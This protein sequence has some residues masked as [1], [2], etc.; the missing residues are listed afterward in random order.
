MTVVS[1]I[2]AKSFLHRTRVAIGSA[3]LLLSGVLLTSVQATDAPL[4]GPA[5]TKTGAPDSELRPFQI[6]PRAAGPDSRIDVSFLLE[7]PAG[8]NGFITARDGHLVKPDGSRQRFWGV[9][10]TDWSRGSV[11]IPDKAD[12]EFHA[13]TLA[14]AGV[15]IV[16]LTFLDFVAP[17]GIIDATRNDT[18]ALDA[19]Q[20]DK[21][22]WWIAALK[23]QGIYTDL[24]L[25]VG[26]TYKEGDGIADHEQIGWAKAL[27]IFD[28]KLIE[29]TKEFA[30][31]LLT[32]RNAYTNTEYRNE[33]AIAIVEV[34][35][36][37]SLL[38][39]WYNDRLRPLDAPVSDAN[40]RPIPARYSEALDQLYQN[41]LQQT[42]GEAGLTNLRARI[43][44]SPG[45]PV[46]RLR[47]ND[48]GAAPSEQFQAE[49]SFYTTLERH[50]YRDMQGYLKNTLKVRAL[51]LGSNDFLG[52]QSFYPTVWA[53]LQMD[54]VDA[55]VY[56]QHPSWPGVNNTPQ[57]NNP[58]WSTLVRLGRAAV[59]GKPF[60]VSEVN[61]AFPNDWLCE[62][63]PTLAA[64]AALQDWDAVMWYTYEPKRSAEHPGYIGDAFDISHDPVRWTQFT[65]GAL[66]FLRGDVAPAREE[67][68]RNYTPNQVYESMRLPRST[69][70]LFTS[71]FP[72][73]LFLRHRVRIGSFE[74][75][76]TPIPLAAT[77]STI[78]SDTHELS[79]VTN[80]ADNGLVTVNA[81]RTQ[82]LVGFVGAHSTQ[83]AHLAAEVRNRFCAIQL[84]SLDEKPI[85]TSALLLLVTGA[86]VENSGTRWNAPRTVTLTR[87]TAPSLIEPVVGRIIL[88]GLRGA[89][90]V[91]ITPL[92]GASRPLASP[93]IA[94]QENG[95]WIFPIGATATPWYEIAVTR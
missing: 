8:K 12:A 78:V 88:K 87:G 38:D 34:I 24:N 92:D 62:G 86:R 37:N 39:A 64:Y 67:V 53:N 52:D 82:A 63:I 58:V 65:A 80:S 4:A 81:P 61:H 9:N 95:F 29:L 26:R 36:E 51:T 25:V 84:T 71:D 3:A 42:L 56:W 17:R 10:I 83:L 60:T 11:Q 44:L 76:T 43:G 40:F 41:F 32:H 21:L 33:P 72:A 59:K 48:F 75:P 54:V 13:R 20:M 85:A 46:P 30:Q 93:I 28:P 89:K 19:V 90:S 55:H 16:R 27:T 5:V 57:V 22:D 49:A 68:V 69:G 7:K 94:V 73:D 6:T 1:P 47:L 66:Q 45:A 74:G 15:N 23:K 35:N 50:Y 18:R 14:R 70:P 91:T 77:N 2:H 31:Q 79:W